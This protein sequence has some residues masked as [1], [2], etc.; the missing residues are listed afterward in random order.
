MAG[1]LHKDEVSTLYQ[2][3]WCSVSVEIGEK[4][5]KLIRE[6]TTLD[7]SQKAEKV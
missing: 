6:Y 2:H 7:L 1:N 4:L 5:Q 3:L